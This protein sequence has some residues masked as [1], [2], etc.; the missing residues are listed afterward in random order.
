MK[1]I[2]RIKNLTI[3]PKD[4]GLATV[5]VGNSNVGKDFKFFLAPV[6]K[7]SFYKDEDKNK[8]KG[9]YLTSRFKKYRISIL[10]KLNN[11]YKVKFVTQ[12]GFWPLTAALSESHESQI[13]NI[14]AI[15]EF[16]TKN[17]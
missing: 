2:F 1:N 9:I 5:Y 17:A 4:S 14:D 11:T 15:Y 12:Y 10:K 13:E 16:L 7:I 3:K 6:N 8:M